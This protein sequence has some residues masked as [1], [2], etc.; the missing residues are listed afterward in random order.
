MT[1]S[2][3]QPRYR[4]CPHLSTRQVDGDLLVFDNRT[5]TAIGMNRTCRAI[6]RLIEQPMTIR[7]VARGLE[8][9]FDM[10]DERSLEDIKAVFNA[11]VAE[12]L[13][14]KLA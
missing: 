9:Q 10:S 14:E 2:S 13:V 11:L 3:P 7:E 1:E 8:S 5:M 6:W 12:K 4:R